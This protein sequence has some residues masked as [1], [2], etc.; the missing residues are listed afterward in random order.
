MEAQ[1]KFTRT[2][3]PTKFAFISFLIDYA[4]KGTE[5]THPMLDQ[6]VRSLPSIKAENSKVDIFFQLRKLFPLKLKKY[7]V[8]TGS[9]TMPDCSEGVK[10]FVA[11]NRVSFKVSQTEIN[12]FQSIENLFN[13]RVLTNSRPVQS[14]NG[15]KI[16]RSF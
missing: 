8:Y 11:R 6:I 3:N 14:S 4:E 7:Y 15:R 9:L 5:Q 16:Y 1:L 13:K 2:D 10:W 12:A